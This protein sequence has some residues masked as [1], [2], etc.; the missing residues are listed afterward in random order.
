M[1][2]F[3]KKPHIL[4]GIAAATAVAGLVA[5]AWP[6]KALEFTTTIPLR[7]KGV[8]TY[9]VDGHIEG[10]GP[11]EFMVDTGSGYMTIN[12]EALNHLK[13]NG[14]A[15]YVKDLGGI[16]ADGSRLRVPVYRLTRI[17]IGDACNLEGI[18]AAVFPGRTRFILGLSALKQTAPF[19]FSVEP[20]PALLLGNCR[21]LPAV[22]SASAVETG[23]QI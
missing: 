21:N 12:E 20:K 23:G 14:Q 15:E 17:T 7:D 1:R 5:T 22:Q 6:V 16:L 9:Y 2:H 3:L 4:G 19:A 11:V 13:K 18:E 10:I 8:A